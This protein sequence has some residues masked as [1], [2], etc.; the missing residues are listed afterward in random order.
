MLEM[1][2][3]EEEHDASNS[4]SAEPPSRKKRKIFFGDFV[5]RDSTLSSHL[6][7]LNDSCVQDIVHVA[8]KTIN[9]KNSEIKLLRQ[10]VRRSL[11]K[12]KTLESLV[13]HLRHKNLTSEEA[14]NAI[15]VY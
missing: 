5:N 14:D 2:V 10:K 13:G 12:I 8:Q 11:K 4:L 1:D 7:S 3:I 15:M 9:K 6:S